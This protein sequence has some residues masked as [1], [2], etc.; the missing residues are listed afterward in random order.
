MLHFG[1]FTIFFV[2]YFAH[3]ECLYLEISTV[4]AQQT[5][6]SL[7]VSK[8][9]WGLCKA[10]SPRNV[11]YYEHLSDIVI[12]ILVTSGILPDGRTTMTT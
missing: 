3:N 10:F 6:R 5:G 8:I 2:K 7:Q 9:L 1:V 4:T 12:W 11:N